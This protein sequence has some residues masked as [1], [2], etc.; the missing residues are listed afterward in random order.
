MRPCF[1]PPAWSASSSMRPRRR[2]PR[3]PGGRRTGGT[4]AEEKNHSTA[5]AESTEESR[6]RG[7]DGIG[8]GLDLLQ[9]DDRLRLFT[10]T[11]TPERFRYLAIL[12]VFDRAR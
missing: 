9:A 4:V 6:G 8:F 11:T 1:P 5:R 3:S 10:F 7:H 12:R 2:R